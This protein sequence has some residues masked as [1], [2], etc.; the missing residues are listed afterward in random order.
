[1]VSSNTEAPTRGRAQGRQVRAWIAATSAI[2]A[3][4]L[5]TLAAPGQ[6]HA[7]SAEAEALFADGD[8][9]MAAGKL[10]EACDAFEASN[11]IEPRAGTLIRL[12]ECREQN[13]QLASAWSAYKDALT[14]VKDPRK[15]EIAVA[16]VAS[17]EPRLSYLTVSVADEARIDGLSITRN[18]KPLDPGLWN[19]AIP[20][21]GGTYTVGGSAPGHEQ[22]RTTVEVPPEG[23]KV[24]VEVPKFKEM[25]KLVEPPPEGP[26]PP[27]GGGA[28][29]PTAETPPG[30][31][32]FTGKRK[33][34]LGLGGAGLVSIGVGAI[35]G[36]KASSSE[37][38]AFALCP[39]PN[40][41]CAKA[42]EANKLIQDGKSQAMIANIS[43]GVGAAAIIGGAVLWF[44]G[45]PEKASGPRVS[46][47]PRIGSSTGIDV[48]VRF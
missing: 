37:N 32:A 28:I 29:G 1:M 27:P 45:G 33:L 22:W 14:R 17:I 9:L 21:D 31:G 15:K 47:R 39:D 3:F 6:A 34:A 42:A 46:I 5:A 36:S 7:Q 43:Y 24:A 38:D 19:R 23:G 44:T 10:P 16:K 26:K 35:F 20:V 13:Q 12:G 41:G 11:R 48:R 4:V 30:G 40:M 2:A 25:I 8:K 18:D